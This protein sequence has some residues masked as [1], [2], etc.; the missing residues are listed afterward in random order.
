MS[1]DRWCQL[2]VCVHGALRW[3]LQACTIEFS[4][5]ISCVLRVALLL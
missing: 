5:N 3:A 2:A 4:R 1:G